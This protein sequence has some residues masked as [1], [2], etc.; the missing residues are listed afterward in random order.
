MDQVHTQDYLQNGTEPQAT[1]YHEST[2][3]YNIGTVRSGLAKVCCTQAG[4]AYAA[5]NVETAWTDQSH[6]FWDVLPV[7]SIAIAR[8]DLSPVI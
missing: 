1:E 2:H 7:A 5:G 3:M 8:R 4:P 6:L